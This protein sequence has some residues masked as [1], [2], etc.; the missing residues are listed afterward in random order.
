MNR[1]HG[2]SQVCAAY[3]LFLLDQYGVLQD[4]LTVFPAA[5]E[6]VRQLATAGKAC[7]IVSNSGRSGDYNRQ[8]LIK[9]GFPGDVLP[10]IITSGDCLKPWIAQQSGGKPV[11]VWSSGPLDHPD[12]QWLPVRDLRDAEVMV[13]NSFGGQPPNDSELHALLDEGFRLGL[14]MI[15]TNPDEVG[16]VGDRQQRSPGHYAR[17]YARQGG[18]VTYFG[19]PYPAI[20]EQAL[21]RFPA[22]SRSR[23]IYLGDSLDHDIAGARASNLDALWILQGVHRA[24]IA[25]DTL[26]ARWDHAQTLAQAS[27]TLPRFALDTFRW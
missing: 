7:L 8:R 23:A 4:G 25:A 1:L 19:K 24:A 11:K 26:D 16:L 5:V 20:F 15:C 13:L 6:A 12:S 27:G 9:H 10:P 14:P 22:I 3:D 2:I 17:A 21:G 18:Q